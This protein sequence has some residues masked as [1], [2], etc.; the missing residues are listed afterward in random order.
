MINPFKEINWK[1]D[2]GEL[3]KFAISL[4]IGFPIIAVVFFLVK[5]LKAG[6][7]PALKFFLMLGG[8]GAGAGMVC[9][10]IPF[11]A[12]PLYYVWYGLAACIGIVVANVLFGVLFYGIFTPLGLVMRL[13][14]RDALGLKSQQKASS[15]WM[16]APPPPKPSSYFSQY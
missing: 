8:I 11:I 10:L 5:W 3:R 1:P 15:Y 14:G 13:I 2:G 4:I 6:E 9:L 12:R 7:L 16:D